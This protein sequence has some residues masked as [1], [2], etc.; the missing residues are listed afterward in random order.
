M[1]DKEY[2]KEWR[3]NHPGYDENWRKDHPKSCKKSK[4]RWKKN[5]PEKVKMSNQ[6]HNKNQKFR[7]HNL[8]YEDWLR[9]WEDQDERCLICGKS[10]IEPSEAC[11]DH[12]HETDEIRGLLCRKCNAGLGLFNDD[13]K[14]I[15]KAMEY[16]LKGKNKF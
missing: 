15:M 6:K 7:Q 5:N 11:I 8:T 4:K 2:M 16:L 3:K 13:H 1:C 9:L 10:F 12:D 14:I